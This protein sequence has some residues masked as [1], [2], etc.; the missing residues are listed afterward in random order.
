M[1]GEGFRGGVT[2]RVVSC[3]EFGHGPTA[4][5][6]FTGC[7]DHVI[8]VWNVKTGDLVEELK[9]HKERIIDLCVSKD[10]KYV[11]KHRKADR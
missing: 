4:D 1:M 6:L 2:G 9:L 10:G 5:L 8:R 11:G 7:W 3:I